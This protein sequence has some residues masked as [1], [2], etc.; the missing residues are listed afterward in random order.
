ME[1]YERKPEYI[2]G[3]VKI[4]AEVLAEMKKLMPGT[5]LGMRK[6]WHNDFFESFY[7]V[8]GELDVFRKKFIRIKGDPANAGEIRC[9]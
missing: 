7:V 9:K 4:S 3:F 2:K 1:N 5:Y 8:A 6:N